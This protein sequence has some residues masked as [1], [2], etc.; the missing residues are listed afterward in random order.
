MEENSTP[1]EKKQAD[2][3]ASE[4]DPGDVRRGS[5]KKYNKGKPNLPSDSFDGDSGNGEKGEKQNNNMLNITVPKTCRDILM[6]DSVVMQIGNRKWLP[7]LMEAMH[8]LATS[9]SRPALFQEEIG[10]LALQLARFRGCNFAEF[11]SVMLAS[12]RFLAFESHG[13]SIR[14]SLVLVF[15]AREDRAGR[16]VS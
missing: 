7:M 10:V 6:F 9:I 11:R 1:E 5:G 8:G 15:A 14:A 16:R 13:G 12:M 4:S 2:A 3:D